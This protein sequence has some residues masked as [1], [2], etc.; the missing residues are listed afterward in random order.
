MKPV[1]IAHQ[2][3]LDDLVLRVCH[4]EL[5]ERMTFADFKEGIRLM[6]KNLDEVLQ[7]LACFAPPNRRIERAVDL[8]KLKAVRLR[9]FCSEMPE[10]DN[11]SEQWRQIARDIIVNYEQFRIEAGML[12][13]LVVPG[14]GFRVLRSA[15]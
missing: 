14:A 2:K 9:S 12:Y 4:L 7:A 8:L 3:P 10:A 11:G 6:L 5:S 1:K 13:E 15:L